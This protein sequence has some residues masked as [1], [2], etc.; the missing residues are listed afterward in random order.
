VV[1][2]TEPVNGTKTGAALLPLSGSVSVYLFAAVAV[3]ALLGA[4]YFLMNQGGTDDPYDYDGGGLQEGL[5]D[6]ED[7][8][9][10]EE[11]EEDDF[12]HE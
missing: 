3:C 11:D 7:E 2:T 8:G 12:D 6:E 1:N 9:Y 4:A 10:E 5:H